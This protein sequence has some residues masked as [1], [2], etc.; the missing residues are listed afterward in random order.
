M[1]TLAKLLRD[2]GMKIKETVLLYPRNMRTNYFRGEG[3]LSAVCNNK[4][5][6]E[7]IFKEYSLDLSTD[8]NV[9]KFLNL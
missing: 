7:K 8:E 6:V 4:T 1:Q 9:K 5:K 3:L 2:S